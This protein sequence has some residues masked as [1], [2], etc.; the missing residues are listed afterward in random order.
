MP[1]SPA[2]DSPPP[3]LGLNPE[4]GDVFVKLHA[5]FALDPTFCFPTD[6]TRLVWQLKTP[7]GVRLLHLNS[8]DIALP[9]ACVLRSALESYLCAR[10]VH[11]RVD[12]P[13]LLHTGDPSLAVV[14]ASRG[15]LE[16]RAAHADATMALLTVTLELLNATLDTP[17]SDQSLESANNGFT[18]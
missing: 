13:P 6:S 16:I 1:S 12:L 10:G 7:D 14:I 8:N 5:L 9:R 11:L 2:A 17:E 3:K 4:I 18:A 15:S